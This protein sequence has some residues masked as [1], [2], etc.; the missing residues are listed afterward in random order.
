MVEKDA[1]SIFQPK[2]DFVILN[3]VLE[4]VDNVDDVTFNFLVELFKR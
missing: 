2:L 4:F 3:K 1:V